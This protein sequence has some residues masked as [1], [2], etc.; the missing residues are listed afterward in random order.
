MDPFLYSKLFMVKKNKECH[1]CMTALL[2]LK[3]SLGTFIYMRKWYLGTF[4]TKC[5]ILYSHKSLSDIFILNVSPSGGA[6]TIFFHS[7]LYRFTSK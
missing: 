6:I 3:F 2:K 1:S 4:Y 7:L 5:T